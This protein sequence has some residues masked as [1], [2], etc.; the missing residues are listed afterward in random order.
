MNPNIK[1]ATV[2]ANNS[3]KLKQNK[4]N[5]NKY[6]HEWL[7][8]CQKINNTLNSFKIHIEIDTN[9]VENSI[10]IKQPIISKE[11]TPFKEIISNG[12]VIEDGTSNV[13][14][15]NSGTF[16]K[17]QLTKL[18]KNKCMEEIKNKNKK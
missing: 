7:Y 14:L 4:I 16:N 1:E 17:M 5:N 2:I 13:V 9:D 18:N 6:I 8:E 15:N 3:L 10:K 11:L 12:V